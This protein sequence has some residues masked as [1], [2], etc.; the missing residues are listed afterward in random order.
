MKEALLAAHFLL[1]SCLAYSSILNMDVTLT[2]E[3]QLISLT[4]W[5]F[6][7]EDSTPQGK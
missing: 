2:Q 1:I 5:H 6:I 7:S 3:Y 4:T